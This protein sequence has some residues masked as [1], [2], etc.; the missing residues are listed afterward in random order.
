[1]LLFFSIIVN[2]IW[3][4]F[5]RF[6]SLYQSQR[7]IELLTTTNIYISSRYCSPHT[8]YKVFFFTHTL[9]SSCENRKGKTLESMESKE[10]CCVISAADKNFISCIWITI[11]RHRCSVRIQ[12]NSH[13]NW[14]SLINSFKWTFF[15][16][17]LG[18]QS[19]YTAHQSKGTL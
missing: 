15:G 7:D 14:K 13:Q 16:I 4:V 2:R 19:I 11:I 3:F 5:C 12:I 6:Y 18:S 9:Y 8:A 1:M 17:K 10:I